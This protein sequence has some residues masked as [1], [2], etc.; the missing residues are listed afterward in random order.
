MFEI[1]SS[2]EISA[3]DDAWRYNKLK[4]LRKELENIQELEEAGIRCM[5]KERVAGAIQHLCEAMGIHNTT[6]LDAL[7]KEKGE[8]SC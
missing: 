2:T 8:N 1:P 7:E 3:L 6:V 5:H 4:M